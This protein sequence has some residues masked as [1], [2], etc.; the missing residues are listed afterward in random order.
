ML[1]KLRLYFCS[2]L[3]IDNFFHCISLAS[4]AHFHGIK[5]IVIIASADIRIYNL[6]WAIIVSCVHSTIVRICTFLVVSRSY[7]VIYITSTFA[8]RFKYIYVVIHCVLAI[9]MAL[10]VTLF[11]TESLW[12]NLK[13]CSYHIPTLAFVL[14]FNATLG[15]CV[16]S[17]WTPHQFFFRCVD[18]RVA[19]LPSVGFSIW[20]RIHVRHR[21]GCCECPA[22]AAS[23]LIW[24]WR[25]APELF[26]S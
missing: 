24:R 7:P 2:S 22:T 14:C 8:L 23:S 10:R 9:L 18:I 12:G 17:L 16:C 5:V 21:I 3:Q 20:Y 6:E 11:S 4:T 1:V 13:E 25:Y 19:W 26:L 15:H